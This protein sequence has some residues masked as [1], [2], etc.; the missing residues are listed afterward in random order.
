M[1]WDFKL[2]NT[3]Y[4]THG[5]HTY[6][7][8]MIPQ[9][10][11]KLLNEFGKNAKVLFDPYC[12]TGTSLV[13]GKI[14]NIDSIGFDLNPLALLIAKTK[15]THIEE[16][17]LKL[18]LENFHKYIFDVFYEK[19]KRDDILLPAYQNIEFW[20]SKRV[21]KDLAHLKNYINNYI[22]NDNVK[23]F[24]NVAFSQ[25]I[26]ECSWTRNDEFK[27][28]RMTEEKMKLFK[29][30]VFS[31]FEGLLSRNYFSLL[32]FNS[33]IKNN[34]SIQTYLHNSCL[35]IPKRIIR[36][37]SV[38][39]VLTSP[40]YGDSSTTV[41]YGQFSS[42][43][44]QWIFEIDTPRSLDKE[45]MGGKRAKN[46]TMF[47]S[48]ILN[49]QVEEISQIDPKR[50]LDVVSFYRDYQKSIN[51]ISTTIKSKGY[52]CYV[53]SNRTVRGVNLQ[54]N[55]ITID[56][57]KLNGFNHIETFERKISNKRLPKHNSPN[58]KLGNKT[59]LMNKEYILIMQKI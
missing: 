7:A 44:N 26:R 19:G 11:D 52:A 10:A 57:F 21:Q 20:F 49:S 3:Q 45:L 33:T 17:T 55:D 31:V 47:R 16:K 8:K 34:A 40:P 42:L 59:G 2:H 15:T 36:P 4:L 38:D 14:R 9:I 23:D 53:V 54:T 46:R 37:E 27:L 56:F 58:G 50:A 18:Y 43:A 51:N 28:Y 12:G 6:P 35:N 24:F 13:E 29:P 1:N 30:D 39:I 32:E 41:A 48:D 22:D 25:T 5:F